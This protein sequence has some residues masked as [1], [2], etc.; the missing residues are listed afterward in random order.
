VAG[1]YMRGKTRLSSS[2]SPVRHKNRLKTIG[3]LGYS[4]FVNSLKL[5][6]WVRAFVAV[7]GISHG[8]VLLT[9]PFMTTVVIPE[10][11]EHSKTHSKMREYALVFKERMD[12]IKRK[13][14][15]GETVTY[16]DRH[17]V[18]EAAKSYRDALEKYVEPSGT[19]DAPAVSRKASVEVFRE[20]GLNVA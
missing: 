11:M 6:N 9:M 8:S 14:D 19:Y 15:A 5:L 10:L 20:A 17:K 2:S 4:A 3:G 18:V 16:E 13:T 1:E 7:A 12:D